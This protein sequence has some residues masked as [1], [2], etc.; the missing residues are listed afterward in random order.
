MNWEAFPFPA[1]LSP[2]LGHTA[3]LVGDKTVYIMGGREGDT[4]MNDV[5]T[6]DCEVSLILPRW[7]SLLATRRKAETAGLYLG[8]QYLSSSNAEYSIGHLQSKLDSRPV[9]VR[10][11]A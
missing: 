4:F 10:C 1:T 6:F 5:W 8:A 7:L 3:T 2:R 11:P 9:S